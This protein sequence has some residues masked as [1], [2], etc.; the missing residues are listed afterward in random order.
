MG[1]LIALLLLTLNGLLGPGVSEAQLE[2]KLAEVIMTEQPAPLKDVK[3]DASGVRADGLDKIE[4][5]FTQL[6]ME[7][8]TIGTATFTVTGI[9][10]AGQDK[11]KLGGISWKG[12]ISEQSLTTALRADG[13]KLKDAVVTVA[14]EGLT[15]RGKWPVAFVSKVGYGVTGNIDVEQQTWLMFSILRSDVSGFGIPKGINGLIEK[16]VNPVYDLARFKARS[17]KEIE[18][19]REKLNYDFELQVEKIV[20]KA[21]HI[22]VSGSA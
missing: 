5:K 12:T 20:P 14:P 9:S 1:D 2:Q 17:R 7:P 10:R 13:G 22:I 15:L 8:L 19:A 4:F 21:G 11:L 6:Y 18:L 3:V 16:E